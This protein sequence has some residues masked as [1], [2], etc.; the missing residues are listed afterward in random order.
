MTEAKEGWQGL[1]ANTTRHGHGRP[2][3]LIRSF[4]P[5][6]SAAILLASCNGNAGGSDYEG[7]TYSPGIG[8]SSSRSDVDAA[9]ILE[10]S[11]A[12]DMEGIIARLTGGGSGGIST[13]SPSTVVLKASDIGMPAGGTAT[14][15]IT[16]NGVD[17]SATASA[18]A[19]GNVTFEIPAIAAGTEITASLTVKNSSGSALYAGSITQTV[20]GDNFQMDIRLSRQ[21]WTLPA[22]LT[23]TASPDGLEYNVDNLTET[24]TLTISGLEDAPAGAAITYAWELDSSPLSDTGPSI[25]RSWGDIIGPTAP[26]DEL[27]KTFTVTVSYTDEAGE[28]KTASASTSVVIGPP[29]II[30]AFTVQI[31]PYSKIDE[32]SSGTNYA[33][34]STYGGGFI[35]KVVEPESYFPAGTSF[36]WSITKSG[37]TS[38]VTATGMSVTKKLDELGLNTAGVTASW[39]VSCTASNARAAAD[40]T[41]GGD[42]SMSGRALKLPKFHLNVTATG[43]D[44]ANSSAS[45]YAFIGASGEKLTITPELDSGETAVTGMKYY[46]TVSGTSISSTEGASGDG[47]ID[48]D[49]SGISGISGSTSA[50]PVT[51]SVSCVLKYTGFSNESASTSISAFML[52]MPTFKIKISSGDLSSSFSTSTTKVFSVGSAAD[53]SKKIQFEAVPDSGQPD[54]PIGTEFTWSFNSA[55]TTDN[56]AEAAVNQFSASVPT[57]QSSY[58]V[59]CSASYASGTLTGSAPGASF[60]LKPTVQLPAPTA[61]GSLEETTSGVS[62]RG[63]A[64]RSGDSYT[65]EKRSTDTSK[66]TI[67]LAWNWTDSS[68]ASVPSGKTVKYKVFAGS[69]QLTTTADKDYYATYYTLGGTSM[70]K[71]CTITIIAFVPGVSDPQ[72][73]DPLVFTVKVN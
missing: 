35:F 16:G 22:S 19:D 72:E 60:D 24:T 61:V 55:S 70:G 1:K 39:T 41:G 46:W 14:L 12:D 45:S 26:A 15:T 34:Y 73:S 57:A 32:N 63:Y 10:M 23:V 65:F 59:T 2:F 13:A 20:S 56:P 66:I 33:F 64:S 28:T 47:H 37:G 53:L 50:S 29:V 54:F 71:T 31:I 38:P 68:P 9:D 8:S 5:V 49:V 44:T 18:D 48:I 27:T 7:E 51:C 30:P 3:R 11:N 62:G 58:P 42:S 21:F 40:V 67:R 6:L 69:T 17:Y 43:N 25:T 4:F 36:T 52:K